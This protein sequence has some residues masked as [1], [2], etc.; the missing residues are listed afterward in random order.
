MQVQRGTDAQEPRPEIPGEEEGLIERMLP[1][2]GGTTG[3][4]VDNPSY[5]LASTT[6]T[7]AS[8]PPCA[9]GVGVEEDEVVLE[10]ADMNP[11]GGGNDECEEATRC[12][13]REEVT[14]GRSVQETPDQAPADPN[15]PPEEEEA[16]AEEEGSVV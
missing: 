15:L 4:P 6:T 10:M 1:S 11:A 14:V 3:D 16:A 2:D 9:D 8:S 7:V 5:Q 13:H 12:R